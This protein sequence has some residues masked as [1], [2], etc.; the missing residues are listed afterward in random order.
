[1]ATFGESILDLM[2]DGK[3]VDH[4]GLLVI[5]SLSPIA[6]GL[7]VVCSAR[8]HAAERPDLTFRGAV[9]GL[10]ATAPGLLLIYFLGLPGAA[11]GIVLV[12]LAPATLLVRSTWGDPSI[13]PGTRTI[14][15]R[16]PP[17]D[18]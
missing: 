7:I 15:A 13:W 2:Y 10:I 8:A 17:A 1:M 12:G 11:I 6:W 3:Y 9:L 4:A 18:G 14:N 16:R 5:L